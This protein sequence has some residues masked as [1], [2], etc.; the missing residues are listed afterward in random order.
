MPR[1]PEQNRIVKDKRKAKITDKALK[2]FAEVGYNNISV[3]QITK[4][5]RCSHGL[6]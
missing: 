5:V 3:D 4:A 2:L 6:F 1:T